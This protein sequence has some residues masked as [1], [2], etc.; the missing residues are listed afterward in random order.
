MVG[1]I[2][3]CNNRRHNPNSPS[4]AARGSLELAETIRQY[5]AMHELPLELAFFKC[6]GRCADG[7]NLK[8]EPA[9]PFVGHLSADKL[10]ELY[11]T[12]ESF[13]KAGE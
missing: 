12:L 2:I 8:L 5:V 11:L 1:K 4:C 13:C 6:L 10:G 7:P 3:I 9:G